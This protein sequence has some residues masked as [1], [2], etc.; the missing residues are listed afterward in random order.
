MT[1]MHHLALRVNDAG[2]SA[3]FYGGLLGLREL[4]RYHDADAD[5]GPRAVWLALGD[6]VLMLERALLPP[7]PTE[8]SAHVLVLGVEDL[9]VWAAKL[10]AAGVAVVE[11]TGFTLYVHDPDGHRVG[12]STFRFVGL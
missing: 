5:A 10:A 2:R 9:D 3:E 1:P 6:A 8:G 12:L 11:R 4:S 7:G